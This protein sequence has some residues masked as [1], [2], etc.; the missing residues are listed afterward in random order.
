MVQRHCIP[1]HPMWILIVQP[2]ASCSIIIDWMIS[3]TVDFV[4]RC[5]IHQWQEGNLVIWLSPGTHWTRLRMEP[6]VLPRATITDHCWSHPDCLLGPPV[7]LFSAGRIHMSATCHC[8]HCTVNHLQNKGASQS[9]TI[10][11][12]LLQRRKS[13]RRKGFQRRWTFEMREAA[14]C[15]SFQQD[16][17][18][19]PLSVVWRL[20]V[21]TLTPC[22]A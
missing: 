17:T 4:F 3:G 14:P 10:R 21:P 13:S 8:L 16:F 7:T 22:F 15:D 9:L 2:K 20:R 19:V 12:V 18:F 6:V 5:I 11:C 1:W